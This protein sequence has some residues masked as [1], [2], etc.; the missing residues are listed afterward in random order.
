MQNETE[1]IFRFTKFTKFVKVWLSEQV[2]QTSNTFEKFSE[3]RKVSWKEFWETLCRYAPAT[4]AMPH[5]GDI[6]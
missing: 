2:L 6:V 3:K 4:A 1:S 5:A